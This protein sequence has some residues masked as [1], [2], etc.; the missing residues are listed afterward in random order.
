MNLHQAVV[1]VELD[2]H[3]NDKNVVSGAETTS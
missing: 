1:R 3:E 2:R